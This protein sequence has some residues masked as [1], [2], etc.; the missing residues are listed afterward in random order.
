VRAREQKEVILLNESLQIEHNK[1]ISNVI[2]LPNTVPNV[3][4]KRVNIVHQSF[5][6]P[7]NGTAFGGGRFIYKAM[8]EKQEIGKNQKIGKE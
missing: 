3:R 6:A 5:C 8:A 1:N 2:D 7:K 4:E